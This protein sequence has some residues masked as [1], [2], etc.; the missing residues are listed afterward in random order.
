LVNEISIYYDAR[1]KKHQNA[2]VNSAAIFSGI[3]LSFV[4][5]TILSAFVK[6]R[7]QY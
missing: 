2:K 7:N 1:S 3:R 5:K 6:L 4:F